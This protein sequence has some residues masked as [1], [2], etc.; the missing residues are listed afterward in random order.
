MKQDDLKYLEDRI[1]RMYDKPP[2]KRPGEDKSKEEEEDDEQLHESKF[3]DNYFEQL[4]YVN[5][6][7]ACVYFDET[8]FFEGMKHYIW[9]SDIQYDEEKPDDWVKEVMSTPVGSIMC[10]PPTIVKL[11]LVLTALESVFAQQHF[12]KTRH[13]DSVLSALERGLSSPG[14]F[15]SL[16]HGNSGVGKTHGIDIAAKVARCQDVFVIQMAQTDYNLLW[17]MEYKGLGGY[18]RGLIKLMWEGNREAVWRKYFRL[19]EKK[20]E[21]P[22]FTEK[23]E[24]LKEVEMIAGLKENP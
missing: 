21:S 20:S 13:I 16:M 6:R 1:N 23:E 3:V 2:S 7:I 18:Q 15:Q 11:I 9:V 10:K 19:P 5:S 17:D 14:N 24:L 4:C 22:E 12:V 8:Q